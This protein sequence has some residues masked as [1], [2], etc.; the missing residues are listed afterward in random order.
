MKTESVN[1]FAKHWRRVL[2]LWLFPLVFMGHVAI[3]DFSAYAMLGQISKWIAYAYLFVSFFWAH[4]LYISRTVTA[5]QAM[6][7]YSPFLVIWLALVLIRALVFAI[8][9]RPL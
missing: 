4:R 8:V 7:L 3:S 6:A 5:V 1:L 9:G 2:P